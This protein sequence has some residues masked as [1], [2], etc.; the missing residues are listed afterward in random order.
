MTIHD[1]QDY[2]A[3]LAAEAVSP[4]QQNPRQVLEVLSSA[5][6]PLFDWVTG[7]TE[8]FR[9]AEEGKLAA[10]LIYEENEERLAAE[11]VA[12]LRTNIHAELLTLAE[13]LGIQERV[14]TASYEAMQLEKIARDM[15]DRCVGDALDNLLEVHNMAATTIP[16]ANPAAEEHTEFL[17]RLYIQQLPEN[18]MEVEAVNDVPSEVPEKG[19]S[20]V[21]QIY[22]SIQQKKGGR[23]C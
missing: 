23:N 11:V 15:A 16:P 13:K 1:T 6:K 14:D 2:I 12:I 3:A 20:W 9:Q 19:E 10:L 7:Q 21:E 17:T 4:Y 22:T 18:S 8:T 5:D